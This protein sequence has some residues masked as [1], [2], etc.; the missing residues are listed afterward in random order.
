MIDYEVHVRDA[1]EGLEATERRAVTGV[2]SYL[3]KM[4]VY[5]RRAMAMYVVGRLQR[6]LSRTSLR[7]IGADTWEI[8][9]GPRTYARWPLYVHGGT[10]IY[11][12]L[13][14]DMIT[15]RH[16]R[17][18]ATVI[19]TRRPR[20]TAAGGG[21]MRFVGRGGRVYFLREVTGQRA[22]PFVRRSYDKTRIY[23]NAQAHRLGREIAGT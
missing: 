3:E 23:A 19:E 12:E 18:P 10:G 17:A 11:R 20:R 13:N 9:V 14:P 6:M 2:I 21:V 8:V 22:N 15:A 5:A 1:T 7:R 16:D 4:G